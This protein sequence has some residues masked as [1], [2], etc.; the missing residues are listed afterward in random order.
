MAKASASPGVAASKSRG[1]C[2]LSP[3][4]T[5]TNR[6]VTYFRKNSPI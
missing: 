5:A 4:L 2:D 3:S 1:L 6:R